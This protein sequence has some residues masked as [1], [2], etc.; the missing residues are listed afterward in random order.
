VTAK[1]DFD[2]F[3]MSNSDVKWS[4]DQNQYEVEDKLVILIINSLFLIHNFF[5]ILYNIVIEI[6]SFDL[7]V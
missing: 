6:R 1:C 7:V 2:L 3:L 4:L 5:H